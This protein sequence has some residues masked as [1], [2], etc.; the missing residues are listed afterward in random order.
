MTKIIAFANQKGGVGKTTSVINCGA[1]LADNGKKV[2]LVDTDPQAH[3]TTGLGISAYKLEITVY[4]VFKGEVEPADTLLDIE[5]DNGSLT[6]LPAS[7]QLS[8]A[9]SEFA[10]KTGREFFL[11]EAL[12]KLENDI[13]LW[14][15]VFDKL[16][17]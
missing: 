3:L 10:G 14:G 17:S 2:L 13:G 16:S 11:K 8:S 1:G 15:M 4:E 5:R 7:I 12:S 9:E 6:L